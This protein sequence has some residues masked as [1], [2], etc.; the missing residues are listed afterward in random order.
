MRKILAVAALLVLASPCF[1]QDKATIQA[2]EDQ[3]AKAFL[4]GDGKAAAAV[5]TEDAILLPPGEPS[6]AGRAAIEDYWGRNSGFAEIALTTT[7]VQPMGSDHAR[8]IGTFAGKTKGDS[9]VVFGGKYVLIW[10]KSSDA[11]LATTDAW[12]ANE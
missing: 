1:A 9:P 4:A 3:L 2:M 7:D 8:E 5:Y 10:Q 12:S 11:W 6:V